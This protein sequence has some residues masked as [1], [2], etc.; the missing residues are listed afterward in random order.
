[1]VL[2]VFS[3]VFMSLYLFLKNIHPPHVIQDIAIV[4]FLRNI[5]PNTVA[6]LETFRLETNH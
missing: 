1:M 4:M 5:Y 6:S 2:M 3:Y